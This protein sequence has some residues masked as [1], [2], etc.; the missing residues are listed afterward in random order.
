MHIGVWVAQSIPP[1]SEFCQLMKYFVIFCV[2]VRAC[3]HNVLHNGCSV[4]PPQAALRL[5]CVISIAGLVCVTGVQTFDFIRFFFTLK[6]IIVCVKE[7]SPLMM[8]L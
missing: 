5:K 7:C 1:L 6:V 3:F 8:R 2:A 4:P